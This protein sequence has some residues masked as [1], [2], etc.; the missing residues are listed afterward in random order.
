MDLNTASLASLAK[1]V[2]VEHAYDLAAWRP[3]LSWAE[4]AGV[5]GLDADDLVRLRRAG[6]RV[7]L[8]GQPLTRREALDASPRR[9]S[10][11][12]GRPSGSVH[13]GCA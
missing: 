1:V 4:V 2:G 12:V 7:K 10:S 6:A 8:P 9:R 11:L 13:K 3:F 5:P